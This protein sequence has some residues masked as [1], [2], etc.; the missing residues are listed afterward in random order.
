MELDFARTVPSFPHQRKRTRRRS[1]SSACLTTSRG[2]A[3][4]ATGVGVGVGSSRRCMYSLI[5]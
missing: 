3:N 2:C 1:A 5:A 4:Y